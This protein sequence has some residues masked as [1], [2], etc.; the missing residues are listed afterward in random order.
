MGRRSSDWVV[1]YW[2]RFCGK[3]DVLV[4]MSLT[5]DPAGTDKHGRRIRMVLHLLASVGLA[6]GWELLLALPE[7]RQIPVVGIIVFFACFG[8]HAWKQISE[9]STKQS[10]WY[11]VDTSLRVVGIFLIVGR[12]FF[13]GR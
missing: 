8:P 2:Q 11:L 1:C 5:S 10:L 6:V 9:K 4:T 12:V 7:G 13:R 3:Q